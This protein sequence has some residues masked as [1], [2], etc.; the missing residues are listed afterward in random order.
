MSR[1][2]CRRY[3]RVKIPTQHCRMCLLNNVS[4]Y[5]PTLSAGEDT[6]A[7]LS[8][9]VKLIVLLHRSNVNDEHQWRDMM[10]GWVSVCRRR[11]QVDCE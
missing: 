3:P 7:A 8:R 2:I 1:V 10:R 9:L 5:L 4:C 11:H 6:N